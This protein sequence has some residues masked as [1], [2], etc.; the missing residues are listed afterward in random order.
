ME[1]SKRMTK[2]FCAG[3]TVLALLAAAPALAQEKTLRYAQR[4]AETGFDPV[5]VY[6][7]YSSNLI[8]QI[9]DPP[10]AYDYLA[11]PAKVVP[12]TA[13]A[14]PEVSEDG[15]V[16]TLR[17][18]PG[19]FFADDPVFQGQRRELTA[20]DYV[21]SLK[22][23]FDPRWN[24][25]N[26]YLIEDTIAG[27]KALRQKSMPGK[28]LDYEREVQGIRALD[29][30]TLQIRLTRPDYNFLYYFTYCNLFC[31]VAREVV[32]HYGEKATEHPVGTGPY[33]L[34]YW[35]RSSKMVFEKNPGFRDERYHA[36]PPATDARSQAIA[37]QLA[38]RKLP[39]IDRVEITVVEEP[40]PRWL[41]FL[42][43]EHDFLEE[44]PAEF[45]DMAIPGNTLAPH[46]AKRGV[47][48]DRVPYMSLD[49]TYFN[50][51]SPVLGGYAPERVALRR[52]IGLS[53]DIDQDLAILRKR[54]AI[55]AHQPVGPGANGY[56]PTFVNPEARYDPARAKALLDAYGYRDVNGDGYREQPDGSALVVELATQPDT[57]GLQTEELWKKSLDGVGIRMVSRRAKWPENLKAARAA[58]LM[59]WSLGWSAAL[60]DAD[61]FYNLFYGP[62]AGQ[63]NLSRFDLPAYNALH[64]R[65]KLLP[66]SPERDALYRDMNRLLIAHAPA[67]LTTHRMWTDLMQPPV[68]GYRKHPVM[69]QWWKFVDL[70]APAAAPPQK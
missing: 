4:V 3:W 11:R 60:P 7:L 2:W 1:R 14:L 23:H 33:R 46:L 39:M 61:T 13:A 52:A 24:S 21:Y 65:A 10:L 63:S 44:L 53:Y 45:A 38:G 49:L 26:L 8:A 62:N 58:K 28:A 18:R 70:Q 35:K 64:A 19:I 12:N 20:H 40:Q 43:G 17:I 41:A 34:A 32:E 57:K 36:E 15:K 42:N 54:Q 9:Y 51:A 29:R 25:P 5:R 66:H 59:M 69:R 37:R 48:M 31:A 16:F 50:M 47:K 22:R 55:I 56:D 67:R 6:D 68:V 30:Y 27:M